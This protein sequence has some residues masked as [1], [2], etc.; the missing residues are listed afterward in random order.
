MA[1]NDTDIL[2][3]TYLLI[4]LRVRYNIKWETRRLQ[5]QPNQTSVNR[6]IE[7]FSLVQ[8]NPHFIILQSSGF[9]SDRLWSL[10]VGGDKI[11][12]VDRRFSIITWAY[13]NLPFFLL[14]YTGVASRPVIRYTWPCGFKHPKL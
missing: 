11:I 5:V 4:Y 9:V 7:S 2:E 12:L 10:V 3:P 13:L 14:E 1:P 8:S 6:V